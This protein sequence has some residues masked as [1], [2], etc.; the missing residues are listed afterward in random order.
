M[1]KATAVKDRA[2]DAARPGPVARVLLVPVRV[3]RRWI[4]PALPPACRFYP[5]CSAYAVEA[6]TVHGALRGS[7]LA[8]RRLLRCGPW[9]PGGLDPVPPRRTENA[10]GTTSPAD[11]TAAEE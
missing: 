5:S 6:L 7:W 1:T 2:A 10:S 11:P 4:S 3:Y 9:H 8:L